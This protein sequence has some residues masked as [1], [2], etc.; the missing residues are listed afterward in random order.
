[1][2][3]YTY[4]N[5]NSFRVWDSIWCCSGFRGYY[6]YFIQWL[7]YYYK[8]Y[9]EH[10]VDGDTWHTAHLCWRIYIIKRRSRG[11]NV[12]YYPVVEGHSKLR[13]LGYRRLGRYSD[14]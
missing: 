3:R 5:S 1:M 14:S 11:R 7:Y 4:F 12:E 13:W 6:L 10:R 9:G 2:E 8:C